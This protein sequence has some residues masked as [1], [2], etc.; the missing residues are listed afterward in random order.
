MSSSQQFDLDGVLGEI[1]VFSS[2]Q[3]KNYIL[4]AFPILASSIYTLTYLFTAAN[5]QYR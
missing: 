1:G 4:L 3:I 2:F 5:P